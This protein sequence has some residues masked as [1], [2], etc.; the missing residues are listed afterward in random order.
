MTGRKSISKSIPRN[1]SEL[2]KM[3]LHHDEL[4]KQLEAE[5]DTERARQHEDM[6]KAL[7]LEGDKLCIELCRELKAEYLKPNTSKEDWI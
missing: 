4:R 2:R 6:A 1:L 3:A 5:G 7:W